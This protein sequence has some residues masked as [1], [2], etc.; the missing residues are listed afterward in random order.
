MNDSTNRDLKTLVERVVRP[1]RA[2]DASI[3][4]IREELLAHLLAIFESEVAEVPDELVALERT[5]ARF[6]DPQFIAQDLQRSIPLASR[7][8]SY[9]DFLWFVDSHQSTWLIARRSALFTFVGYL[10]LVLPAFLILSVSRPEKLPASLAAVVA[11]VAACFVSAFT[12][13]FMLFAVSISRTMHP[14]GDRSTLRLALLC[15]A[16][17]AIFPGL[18]FVSVGLLSGDLSESL[19]HLRRGCYFAPIA[20]LMFLAMSRQFAEEMRYHGEWSELEIE[21]SR[22][23]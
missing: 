14:A 19:V 23:S 12:F 8:R 3:R 17:L 18:A 5:K 1:L 7:V 10:G 16:S 9:F 13:S 22:A 11:L 6:G 21:D 2:S 15:I 20:P 4:R